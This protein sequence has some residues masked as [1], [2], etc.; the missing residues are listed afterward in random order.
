MLDER[1]KTE[2]LRIYVEAARRCHGPGVI[3][4]SVTDAKVS[5]DPGWNPDAADPDGVWTLCWVWTPM[6]EVR[7]VYGDE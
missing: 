1:T 3:S 6:A 4:G 7:A 2:I 5:T